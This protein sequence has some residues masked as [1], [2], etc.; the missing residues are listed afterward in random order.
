MAYQVRQRDPL[1][2]A[3]TQAVLEKR[4]RELLGVV[5]VVLAGLTA[6]LLSTYSPNDPSWISATD[7]P[8]QNALGG[9]G[10]AVAS[11][12]YVILGLAS[13]G[14]VLTLAS[15]GARLVMH[16]GTDRA[17]TRLIFA[18]IAVGL[19]ALY[20]STLVPY[21]GWG[22]SFGL[23][24]LLGDTILGAMLGLVPFGVGI[25][26][27]VFSVAFGVGAVALFCYALGFTKSEIKGLGRFLVF[28]LIVAYVA[29]RAALF[30]LLGGVIYLARR[31]AQT[32]SESR[33]ARLSETETDVPDFMEVDDEIERPSFL[34]RLRARVSRPE[35]ENEL[36]EPTGPAG[37]VAAPS[38]DQISNRILGGLSP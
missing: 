28:G 7:A 4:G 22:H 8:V 27:K 15:W 26:L 36:I 33:D 32:W 2:D 29:V 35:P 38:E 11:P 30:W 34:E 9:L 17:T 24:G 10:A 1:F 5:L 16:H 37:E 31:A 25:A 20:A 14:V 6:V 19:A 18:P 12:L 23:G 3:E 21:Q 13:W